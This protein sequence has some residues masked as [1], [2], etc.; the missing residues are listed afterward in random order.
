MAFVTD[1]PCTASTDKSGNYV[2][3]DTNTITPRP[4]F[5]LSEETQTTGAG[6]I[7]QHVVDDIVDNYLTTVYLNIQLREMNREVALFPGDRH[8]LLQYCKHRSCR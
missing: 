6:E 1:R 8:C 5:A 4:E 2:D 7:H 3:V